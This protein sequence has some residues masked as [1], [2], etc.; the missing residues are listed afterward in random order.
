MSRGSEGGAEPSE[1]VIKNKPSFSPIFLTTT[2]LPMASRQ[3][4]G[5][6]EQGPSKKRRLPGACDLCKVSELY[7][8]IIA[9]SAHS[10]VY[11]R[12]CRRGKVSWYEPTPLF[13]Y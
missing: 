3:Q 2:T 4:N 1:S 5:H 12:V 7:L 13:L 11:H 10:Q 8:I 9:T 6:N